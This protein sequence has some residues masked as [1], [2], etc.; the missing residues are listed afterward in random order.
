MSIFDDDIDV[1]F[2]PRPSTSASV[3]SSSTSSEPLFLP[4]DDNSDNEDLTAGQQRD[5]DPVVGDIFDNVLENDENFNYV[6]LARKTTDYD[7][8]QREAEKRAKAKPL[9]P[10]REIVSSSPPPPDLGGTNDTGGSKKSTGKK[11]KEKR[12]PMRLDEARLVGPT[13]FPQ[14]IEDTKAFKIKGK[15]H[16]ARDLNRLLQIYQYWT[17]RM[18]PKSQFKD[19]VD[20]VEKLCHSKLMQNKLSMWRDEVHSKAHPD[21]E[22]AEGEIADDGEAVDPDETIPGRKP[23]S[24]PRSDAAAYAS[25]S[26]SPPA[27]PPS[28]VAPSNTGDEITAEEMAEME[29]EMERRKEAAKATQSTTQNT[30]SNG[31]EFMMDVDDDLEAWMALE[32][33]HD[34]RSMATSRTASTG[35][36]PTTVPASSKTPINNARIASDVDDEQMWELSREME[37]EEWGGQKQAVA[38]E[39]QSL[40]PQANLVTSERRLSTAEEGFDNEMYG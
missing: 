12:K 21:L 36:S 4:G 37:V 22:E 34:D 29:M 24:G 35:R 32:E 18:Y 38:K 11:E 5:I 7:E 30:P 9:P 40:D 2:V 27:R 16:E 6:P 26:L 17:H 31:D 8:L 10:R 3:R 33:A 19:T 13:G 39:V 14:L 20:R 25:S 15:G 23:S 1:E 28:S